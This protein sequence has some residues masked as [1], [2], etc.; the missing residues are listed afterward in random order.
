[1]PGMR[2]VVATLTVVLRLAQ[3]QYGRC[4]TLS[5]LLAVSL[6]HISDSTAANLLPGFGIEVYS[7]GASIPGMNDA[8]FGPGGDFGTDLFVISNDNNQVLTVAGDGTVSEYV[9]PADGINGPSALA[10]STGGAFGN[11]LYLNNEDPPDGISSVNPVTKA[12][13]GG[14]ASINEGTA[15]VLSD[16]GAFG[17]FLY[18]GQ[19][20]AGTPPNAIFQVDSAFNVSTFASF[21]NN[22]GINNL[23]ISNGGTFGTFLYAVVRYSGGAEVLRFSPGGVMEVF[24]DDPMSVR[25]WLAFSPGGVWGDFLYLSDLNNHRIYRIDGAGNRSLFASDLSF[26]APLV[27]APDGASLFVVQTNSENPVMRIFP[28]SSAVPEPSTFALAALGLLSLSFVASRR[29]RRA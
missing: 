12:V 29:R 15:L 14:L 4:L 28:V 11:A 16:G 26:P 20:V 24:N 13:T 2:N 3:N 1:M 19:S 10:F 7:P 8:A 21:G 6:T 27:F 18:A 25:G 17:N 23:A 9:G 22:E 5:L